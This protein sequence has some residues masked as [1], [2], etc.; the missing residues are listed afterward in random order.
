[1]VCLN[2]TIVAAT[3][4]SIPRRSN[5]LRSLNWWSREVEVEIKKKGNRRKMHAG[6]HVEREG[7]KTDI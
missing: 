3:K 4:H 5:T 1:M 6:T 2:A 7:R